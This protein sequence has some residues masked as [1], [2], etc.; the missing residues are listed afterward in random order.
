MPGWT[1][2]SKPTGASY[3]K[4]SPQGNEFFDDAGVD[5][6]DADVYF[7]GINSSAWTMVAR[8]TTNE[9]INVGMTIGLLMPLKQSRAV[10][11]GDHWTRFVK[12]S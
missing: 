5:F 4:L 12:P 6:D 3:T 9:F 2:V 11:T 10:R 8:E 1:N 7:N